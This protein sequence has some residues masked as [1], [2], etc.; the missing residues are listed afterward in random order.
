MTVPVLIQRKY[1]FAWEFHLDRK[2]SNTQFEAISYENEVTTITL[3]YSLYGDVVWCLITRYPDEGE[4][5]PYPVGL[6]LPFSQIDTRT[7]QVEGDHRTTPLYFG[8]LYEM[9]YVFSPL[10][11]REAL[12]SGG[13]AVVT[14]G[15]LQLRKWD[16]VYGP[17][18]YFEVLVTPKLRDTRAYVY[19]GYI[20]ED[21]RVTLGEKPMESGIFTIPIY[22]QSTD[23]T[24]EIRNS[25]YWPCRLLAVEW[26]GYYASRSGRGGA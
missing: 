4:F 12:P 3:P 21:G 10:Y 18:G 19:N 20:L 5:Q 22:C 13:E 15:R 1:G 2:I 23:A 11:L 8:N 16:I 14:N 26:E 9:R 25:S 7:I 6:S 24:V 17:S